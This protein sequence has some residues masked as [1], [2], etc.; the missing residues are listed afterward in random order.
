MTA[1]GAIPEKMLAE[2]SAT[3]DSTDIEYL[4]EEIPKTIEQSLNGVLRVE[5]IVRAMKDFSH[6]GDEEKTL[7][8]INAILQTT[9]T[10]CRN[11]WKYVAELV[12]DLAEDLPLVPCFAP[13]IGQ[14]FLNIIVNGAHAIG[15]TLEG[16]KKTMGTITI[17]SHLAGDMVQ[18]RI[19]D[20][21]DGIPEE[22]Q[23]RIFEPFFT[24]KQRGKGTGQGLA[25]AR[26]IVENKH[27]GQIS[28]ETEKGR[29]TTFVIE[30]PLQ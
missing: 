1:V 9:A 2:V 28:F 29:G 12:T 26:R 10:I 23:Q 24:T 3:R 5:K 6:P 21:G 13:E 25:I 4:T 30:L 16:G 8:N 7:A 22:V 17:H 15:E 19:Q 27:H 11:E 18:V 14:V 20:S